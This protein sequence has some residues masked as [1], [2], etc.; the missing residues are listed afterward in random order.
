MAKKG[1]KATRK[2]AASGQLKK[3]IQARHKHQQLKKNIE[4]RKGARTGRGASSHG[5]GRGGD[6]GEEDDGGE[7]RE[8]KGKSKKCV[9]F[10]SP[11]FSYFMDPCGPGRKCPWTIFLELVLWPKMMMRYVHY[12]YYHAVSDI[13][14]DTAFR[15]EVSTLTLRWTRPKKRRMK[16]VTMT[17]SRSLRSMPL[18]VICCSLLFSHCAE[19]LCTE[20]GALHLEEL[21]KLAEKDPEFYKYL[22]ENDREL[23]DFDPNAID[24][25]SEDEAEGE[26]DGMDVEQDKAPVLTSQILKKWQKALLEVSL[27]ALVDIRLFPHADFAR[28]TSNGHCARYENSLLHSELLLI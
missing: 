23:L 27:Y 9:Q 14:L 5:K 3:Q 21:S 20:D 26:E 7:D 18:T 11:L 17:T 2:F 28:I 4:R 1:A 13:I 10:T 12:F 6:D 24:Q 19:S 16:R 8:V 22:Q 15:K 25:D